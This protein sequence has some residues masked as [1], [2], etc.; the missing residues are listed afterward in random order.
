MGPTATTPFVNALVSGQLA[1]N[2]P[3]H[4]ATQP[5]VAPASRPAASAPSGNGT[6]WKGADGNVYVAGSKGVNAAGQWDG[7][8]Q[9]YWTSR[10]FKM[11]SDP[12]APKTPGVNSNVIGANTGASGGGTVYPDKSNDIAMQTAGLGNIQS[13]EDASLGK[14]TDTYN[15]VMG[16][17]NGDLADANKSYT[18]NSND[19]RNDLETNKGTALENARQ[20]RQ[21]LFGTLASL[22]ALNGSGIDLAN[23]AVRRGA[24]EDLKTASDNYATNQST[25][26]SGYTKYKKDEQKLIDQA[27]RAYGNDQEQVKNDSAKQRQ[28]FLINIANDYQDEGNTAKAKTFMDQA[29]ALFPEISQTSVPNMDIGYSGGAYVAPTLNQ[30]VGQANNTSVRSTP[31]SNTGGTSLFNIPGLVAENKRVAA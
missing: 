18:N 2:S 15:S 30:Y 21:G 3:Y 16:E 7:N 8:T 13:G 26:D 31:G 19:N 23:E 27:N 25:L 17:Y 14:L 1:A 29:S 24:N 5:S 22:G 6:F 28:Q 10:G 20:G 9:N 12:N 4:A 11:Q